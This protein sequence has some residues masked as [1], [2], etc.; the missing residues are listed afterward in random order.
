MS[1][2][3]D[4]ILG[5]IRKKD[6][7]D[8]SR[9][10]DRSRETESDYSIQRINN[11]GGDALIIDVRSSQGSANWVVGKFGNALNNPSDKFVVVPDNAAYHAIGSAGDYTIEFLIKG[12]DYLNQGY[13]R[14]VGAANYPSQFFRIGS[15]PGGMFMQSGSNFI[16]M[17][18]D[19]AFINDWNH[20]ALVRYSGSLSFY[21]NGVLKAGN[22][23]TYDLGYSSLL[24][25][26]F[27]GRTFAGSMD[28]F[29][30]SNVAR[31]TSNFTPPAIEHTPDISTLLLLHFNE[32]SGITAFDSSSITNNG[33]VANILTGSFPTNVVLIN[34]GGNVANFKISGQYKSTVQQGVKPFDVGSTTMN[35]NLNADMLDDLHASDFLQIVSGATGSFTTVDLKTVTVVNG[36]ITSII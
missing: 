22:V 34:S 12:A 28:E 1:I 7:Q 20:I 18:M 15:D 25:I 30:F 8:L 9:F 10:I 17:N 36:Q 6:E 21:L 32:T 13:F 29:R 35:D 4:T 23:D 11:A 5:K 2:I 24:E 26:M 3:V 14:K 27:D 31:Y 33:T 16:Q 19:D